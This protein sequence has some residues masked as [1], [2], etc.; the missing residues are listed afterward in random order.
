MYY[1]KEF[2]LDNISQIPP[3]DTDKGSEAKNLGIASFITSIL[4]I[5]IVG[6]VLGIVALNKSK[7]H[8][9]NN[10]FA[11]GGIVVSSLGMVLTVLFFVGLMMGSLSALQANQKQYKENLAK[12]A[13][14]QSTSGST[15]SVTETRPM[16]AIIMSKPSDGVFYPEDAESVTYEYLPSNIKATLTEKD[17]KLIL[18]TTYEWEDQMT[19][20]GGQNSGSD[21]VTKYPY[22][23]DYL[24]EK[25][26]ANDKPYTKAQ[27]DAVLES[28]LVY[29]RYIG[30]VN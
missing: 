6:L 4:G 23:E 17:V 15:L 8:S 16:S 19:A 12:N 18:D 1:Y 27:I 24:Y 7:K 2:N 25:L 13:T 26:T 5:H 11:V 28:E 20:D 14:T 29:L 9:Q 10:G 22:V 21:F 30:A 3:V